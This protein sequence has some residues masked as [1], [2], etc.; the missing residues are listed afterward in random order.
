M[1]EYNLSPTKANYYSQRNNQ[2]DPKV[3][4]KPT[5][6][7]EALA[8]AGW[9]FP[10]NEQYPQPEDALTAQCRTGDAQT[11][12]LRADPKAQGQNPNEYWEVIAWAVNALWYPKQRPLIG[13]RWNWTIREALHGIIR[14]VPFVASTKLTASGHVVNIVGFTTEQEGD[15]FDSISLDLGAVKEIIIDDPYGDRTSGRYNLDKTGWNNRYPIADFMKLW[16]G[17]GVQ[18]RPNK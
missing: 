15:V 5:A 14:G 4:C 10:K 1:R 2:I 17:V 11:I 8:I 18:I 6:T 16:T 3:T 13:P 12:M 9:P 7:V